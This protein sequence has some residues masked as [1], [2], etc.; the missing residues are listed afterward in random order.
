MKKIYS[1]FK[2]LC[3]TMCCLLASIHGYAALSG[4]YTINP[5]LAASASNYQSFQSAVS[6]LQ[7]G[8]RADGGIPNGIGVSGPVVF[9]IAPGTYT[10]QINIAGA[11][12]GTSAVNS[13]TFEGTDASTR[14]IEYF[15]AVTNS[16]HTIRLDSVQYISF[17]NLTIR[18]LGDYGWAIHLNGVNTN[19]IKIKHCVIDMAGV[20]V[21]AT[22]PTHV[23]ILAN[24]NL[25]NIGNGAG[26]LGY[27][28]DSLEIDSNTIYNGYCGIVLFSDFGADQLDNRIRNNKIINASNWGI[29][30]MFQNG[31]HVIDNEVRPR[32]SLTQLGYGITLE[33]ITTTTPSTMIVSGN[34]VSRYGM[35]G[36]N[37]FNVINMSAMKTRVFNNMLSDGS[38]TGLR[39]D[40][41]EQMD[42][43][44]NSV[45]IRD[46]FEWTEDAAC[47]VY[48][49]TGLTVNNNIFSVT[50]TGDILPFFA[51]DPFA[52][53]DLDYNIYYRTDVSDGRLI[54][55]GSTLSPATYSGAF[56]YNLNS[57]L[58]A[59]AFINDTNLRVLN[60]CQ[61]GIS[62]PFVFED[63]DG[64]LR[65]SPPTIGAHEGLPLRHNLKLQKV[66][67]PVAPISAGLQ[68]LVLSIQNLGDSIVDSF[69]ISYVHNGN[70]PVTQTWTGT[71]NP[72]DTVWVTFTGANQVNMDTANILMVYT[73]LPNGV[74]DP[75]TANDTIYPRMYTAM[76]GHYVIGSGPAASFATFSD[77]VTALKLGGISDAVDFEVEPGTYAEQVLLDEDILGISTTNTIT[78]DGMDASTR[79][80]EYDASGMEKYYTFQVASDHVRLRNLTI[81]ASSMD[82]GWGIL[83]SKNGIKNVHIKNCVIDLP[84]AFADDVFGGIALSPY[85][86]LY[87]ESDFRAD[88]IEIDSNTIYNGFVGIMH[89]NSYFN[90]EPPSERILIRNNS[91]YNNTQMGI[92]SNKANSL[93]VSNNTILM[94]N[95]Q[96]E[97]VTGISAENADGLTI[98]SNLIRN[99][100]NSGIGIYYYSNNT[101]RGLLANNSI[102][103]SGYDGIYIADV[104]DMDILHNSVKLDKAMTFPVA[105]ALNIQFGGSGSSG[106]VVANNNLTVAVQGTTAAAF[107]C[108]DLAAFSSCDYNNMYKPDASKVA[109]LDGVWYSSTTLAGASG[110]NTSSISVEPEFINDTML[111]SKNGCMNGVAFASVPNDISGI[112]RGV[113]PDMGAYEIS[114]PGN[115]LAVVKIVSPVFPVDSGTQDLY[116]LIANRGDNPVSSGNIS[117]RLNGG[118]VMTQVLPVSLGVCDTA[119]IVFS[120]VNQVHLAYGVPNALSVFTD[121]PNGSLDNNLAND[122]LNTSLATPMTGIYT[123]G[124]SGADYVTLNDANVDLGKRGVSGPVVFNI[125]TGI[126]TE[127]LILNNVNGLSAVNNIT[128][129]SSAQHADSVQIE[130]AST[131]TSDNFVFQ[132]FDAFYYNF[133]YLNIRNAGTGVILLKGTSSYVSVDHCKIECGAAYGTSGVDYGAGVTASDFYTGNNLTITN[134]TITGGMAGILIYGY[135]ASQV[136][137]SN[138]VSGNTVSGF[139]FAGIYT[140]Y[141]SNLTINRNIVTGSSS[142]SAPVGLYCFNSD[143]AIHI[144]ANKITMTSGGY[145]INTQGCDGTVAQPGLIADNVVIVTGNKAAW[146]IR[147]QASSRMRIYHNSVKVN[148]P[149]TSYAAYLHYNGTAYRFN[150]VKNNVFS[151]TGTGVALY[152]HNPLAPLIN[153]ACDYN[154]L[155]ATGANLVQ[156]GTPSTLYPNLTAWKALTSFGIE[157]HSVSYRPGFTG[158]NDLTPNPS[159]SASWSINGRGTHL[160]ST[161]TGLDLNGV[162]RP[163]ITSEGAPDIG[164]YEFTPLSIPP[165]ATAIP[166]TPV[167][168]ALQVFMFASDTVAKIHWDPS[169]A[170]PSA[171]AIRYYSGESPPYISSSDFHTKAYWSV[172]ADPGGYG[173]TLDVHYNDPLI[174]NLPDESQMKTAQHISGSGWNI[175][176]SVAST[177]DTSLNMLSTLWLTDFDML[178]T[179]TD[180]STPLPVTLSFFT[181]ALKRNHVEASWV[182]ASEINNRGFEVERLCAAGQWKSIG[183]VQG[184]GNS[185]VST[186]YLFTDE[187]AFIKTGANTLYYRLKQLD[188]N[189]SFTYSSIVSVSTQDYKAVHAMVFPNP[190]ARSFT[191]SFDAA[192]T[193]LASISVVDLQGR[194][195]AEQTSIVNKGTNNI[196]LDRLSD[197]ET[198]V[199]FIR[200]SVGEETTTLKVVKQ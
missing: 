69:N 75:Y 4:G 29:Y 144:T 7:T 46:A 25:T 21:T 196:V 117:Y 106:L 31:L 24:V 62:V 33:N 42:V 182:T 199:Y 115:D 118:P 60:S 51:T 79:I 141:N 197:L 97:N 166:A 13:V 134:N 102:I 44:N 127:Q 194:T 119:T 6:D 19:S 11:I 5:S 135:S 123:I 185:N 16:R 98:T 109:L 48:G 120:G 92:Y 122:T 23:G 171:V 150:E 177:V 37:L 12:P 22:I 200:V 77:A 129:T 175:F 99:V 90:Q 86:S 101:N 107:T 186:S 49:G 15:A 54:F 146:G 47:Y 192:N 52:F 32:S 58:T 68:D 28:S 130:Y 67:A 94:N 91:L 113:F 170:V 36:L 8:L 66:E 53:D 84:Y 3:I 181:A 112:T 151:N 10:G 20:G 162:R 195:V 26:P 128:F 143:T 164:A 95:T 184:K 39:M 70:T 147:S 65:N 168:G 116:V 71:L 126:Y 154:N 40:G 64:N 193:G 139:Y 198:G 73:S 137:S 157:A 34:E 83:I 121:S 136:S 56:G 131:G 43:Y 176:S 81:R 138:V 190:F 50:R 78:F 87:S 148:T 189:G 188:N 180:N 167:A 145:G 74:S 82:Y 178:I 153:A 163:A 14:I 96:L 172:V 18:T 59:S 93:D 100:N 88:S 105:G 161:M 165:V 2:V 179:G 80:V 38:G 158:T 45:T 1:L 169:F 63:I 72:C 160:D 85:P 9:N 156:R 30:V 191:V 27:Y 149:V 183:F 125:Q 173:Y 89:N 152:Y 124:V 114:Q 110:L 35:V 142:Y 55:M 132:L 103:S 17:R 140:N 57:M 174:G 41:C 76:H 61:K 159:D 187:D 111:I 155:Y 104:T 108:D 133:T